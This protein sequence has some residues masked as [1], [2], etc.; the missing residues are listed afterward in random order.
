M[1][2]RTHHDRPCSDDADGHGPGTAPTVR[3]LEELKVAADLLI[4][5]ADRYGGSVLVLGCDRHGAA[6][7]PVLVSD[8]RPSASPHE[9]EPLLDALVAM[10]AEV[11]GSI[12]WARG[13]SGTAW[14]TDDD[15]RWHEMVI[16]AC[17]KHRVSLVGAVVVLPDAVLG[18]P[19]PLV[20]ELGRG[21]GSGGRAPAA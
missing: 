21:G 14:V 8:V 2:E 4:A 7:A 15:R 5:P 11:G 18:L 20:D 16:A 3:T 19:E 10:T 12:A 1:P 17:R 6:I 9:I 13:R